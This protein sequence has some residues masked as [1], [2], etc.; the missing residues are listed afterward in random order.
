MELLDEV[1]LLGDERLMG[2]ISLASVAIVLVGVIALAALWA[3]GVALGPMGWV[4]WV[5]GAVAWVASLG[6]HELIHGLLF[7]LLGPAGLHVSFSMGPGILCTRAEGAVLSPGRFLVVL[8]GPAVVI[9]AL[10]LAV[11]LAGLPAVALVVGTLHL[12]GC[13]GDMAMASR[14]LSVRCAGAVEDTET[15]CRVWGGQ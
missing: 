5:G 8:L 10:W 6:L 7:R 1:D 2:F 12:A 14:I 4:V 11:A 9:S 3:T 13:T 15:G